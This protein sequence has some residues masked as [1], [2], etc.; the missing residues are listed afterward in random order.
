MKI[1][2]GDKVKILLGKDRGQEGTVEMVWGK[3]QAV[4]V[5]GLNTFKKHVKPHGEGEKGGIID[6]SRP[7]GVSRVRLVCPKCGKAVR[8]GYQTVAEKKVRICLK[9]KAGI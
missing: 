7:I 9:C 4:L 6:K 2:K 3:K 8:V 1:K 5:S